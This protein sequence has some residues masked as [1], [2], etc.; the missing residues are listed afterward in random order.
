MRRL[1]LTLC[2]LL[3]ALSP[4]FAQNVK[5]DDVAGNE[6]VKKIMETRPGRGVMRD[7]TPPTAP[8]EAVKL[9]KTRSDVAIDLMAHEPVVEQPLYVS[10]DSKA[11]C[12]S[13]SIAS[14][15]FPPD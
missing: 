11:A 2:P 9:F 7:D 15:N 13:R 14:I 3:S 6:A 1:F 5:P 10:W 8:Q 4:T 12:G